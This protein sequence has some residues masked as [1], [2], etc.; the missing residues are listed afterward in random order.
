MSTEEENGLTLQGL[1]KRLEILER[2]NERMRSEKGELRSK[3]APLEGS[4]MR[5]DDAPLLESD[6]RVSRRQLL[7]KAGVAAAGLV[8]AGALTQR[9]IREA[10]A[11][12]LIGDSDQAFQG[13]VEGTNNHVNGYGVKGEVGNDG[14]IGVFGEGVRPGSVGV[15]GSNA[16]DGDGV[17]GKGKNGVFGESAT[18]DQ[19]GV[20][21]KHANQGAGVFGEG[22]VGVLG[23]SSE[24]SWN[25]VWGH[26]TANG[27]GVAGDSAQG[28][29]VYGQST[30]GYGGEFKGG[31]AQLKL[32][33]ATTAGKPTG[34]H[35][36][37]EIYMDSTGTLFICVASSTSTAAA[38]WK[39]V[40]AVAV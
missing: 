20:W 18:A 36:K 30:S 34:T 40:S 25:G 13:G 7:S 38:K 16:G 26:H 9:D 24:T 31:K 1:A 23:I 22:R 14:G 4:G 27:R 3:V 10:K 39:K 33:P 6:R 29:G 35:T 8:V 17:H 15:F 28:T 11:V 5:R 12:Q 21:G 32:A 2:E 19:N 37:G